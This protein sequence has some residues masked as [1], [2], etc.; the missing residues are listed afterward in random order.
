MTRLPRRRQKH[1][2]P[3]AQEGLRW[4]NDLPPELL[5]IIASKTSTAA[6]YESLRSVCSSWRRSLSMTPFPP[7]PFDQILF[8]LIPP[9][10]TYPPTP[11]PLGYPFPLPFAIP[12]RGAAF[13]PL[14]QL[15]DTLGC[16]CVGSSHGWLISLD[17]KSCISLINPVTADSIPLPSL[18]SMGNTVLS[19]NEH[20]HWEPE[21]RLR[22]GRHFF[23]FSIVWRA[24][25][26]SDPVRDPGFTVLLFLSGLTNCCFTWRPGCTRWCQYMH[27][28]FLVEDVVFVKGVFA[29]IDLSINLAIFDFRNLETGLI[30]THQKTLLRFL[31][32]QA[33]W[34]EAAGDLLL[35][36]KWVDSRQLRM[37]K[38][39]IQIFLIRV[40][41]D[42]DGISGAEAI[43]IGR[44]KN[45][46]LFVGHGSSV[47]VTVEQFPWL[48]A[49]TVYFTHF[50]T[51]AGKVEK[52]VYHGGVYKFTV[53]S[54][55]ARR[56]FAVGPPRYSVLWSCLRFH[57][58]TPNLNRLNS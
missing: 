2:P 4:A 42:V 10:D 41:E 16:V 9:R 27:Q 34:V 12:S 25:L 26:S 35:V 5:S 18:S 30:I 58:V 21:Y 51:R 55:A 53:L 20:A 11:C 47:C 45:C 52:V 14:P 50:Y 46:V 19:F 7:L 1:K 37:P 22:N 54:K 44:L 17:R 32:K 48:A 8:L 36:L 40:R 57:W 49:D 29:A 6:N 43:E 13:L 33:F 3:T 24:V 15:I 39:A 31:P 38:G 23:R 56:A 28:P